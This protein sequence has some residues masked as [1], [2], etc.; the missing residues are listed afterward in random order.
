MTSRATCSPYSP[1]ACD[2]A[3]CVSAA[4]LAEGGSKR[5]AAAASAANISKKGMKLEGN[6]GIPMPHGC[7][8]AQLVKTREER[9]V[10]ISET[11]SFDGSELFLLGRP[12]AG[13]KALSISS[14]PC[15]KLPSK[16]PYCQTSCRSIIK[17]SIPR[18]S[19]F[20]NLHT[21]L[22]KC[23]SILF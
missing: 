16:K 19:L 21:T 8:G 3:C 17:N 15:P 7:C 22:T 20:T 5:S 23:K 13:F 9:A 18:P 10:Q 11:H 2:T 4:M 14:S 12:T 6:L 1:R